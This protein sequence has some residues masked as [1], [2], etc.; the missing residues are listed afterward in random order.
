MQD[1]RLY[2]TTDP[3]SFHVRAGEVVGLAGL[4]GS[5]RT[6]VAD[7]LADLARLAEE[8]GCPQLLPFGRQRAEPG[9]RE[10]LL[11]EHGARHEGD[12]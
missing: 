4:V 12:R 1:L 11:D 3:F 10:D 6:T 5:G 7:T 9:P 8:Y 2:P